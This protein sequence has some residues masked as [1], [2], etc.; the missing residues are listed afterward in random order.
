MPVKD[1]PC[2]ILKSITLLYRTVKLLCF[3]KK[4]LTIFY[5]YFVCA[6]FTK[7][8]EFLS[9]ALEPENNSA[10]KNILCMLNGLNSKEQLNN[11]CKYT[12][13]FISSKS[14]AQVVA[15]QF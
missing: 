4:G 6:C 11:Y 13:K 2:F 7:E 1:L 8:E 14:N 12:G 3:Q 10:P 15:D 9:F 5:I